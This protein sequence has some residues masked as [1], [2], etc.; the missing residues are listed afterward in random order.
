MIPLRSSHAV[1]IRGNSPADR[2]AVRVVEGLRGGE[3]AHARGRS[4]STNKSSS[5]VCIYTVR[6]LSRLAH[7][8]E[9]HGCAATASEG[10]CLFM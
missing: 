8:P 3:Q 5:R 1:K 6:P 9:L 10:A 4:I 2:G 7:L